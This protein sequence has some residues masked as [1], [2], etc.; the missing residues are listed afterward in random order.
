MDWTQLIA[1]VQNIGIPGFLVVGGGVWFAR[2]A[3]PA[4]VDLARRYADAL[5]RVADAL[6]ALAEKMP[7]VQQ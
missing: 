3:F 1:I 6:E 2:A 7:E 4:L 5:C